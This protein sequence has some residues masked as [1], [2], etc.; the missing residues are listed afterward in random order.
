MQLLGLGIQRVAVEGLRHLVL[1]MFSSILVYCAQRHD[2]SGTEG[3]KQI[4][5]SANY[6]STSMCD[7]WQPHSEDGYV[8]F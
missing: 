5:I 3:K 4:V 8:S 6:V 1:D 2:H 7:A